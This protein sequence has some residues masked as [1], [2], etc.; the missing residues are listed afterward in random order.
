MYEG[1]RINR[2]YLTSEMILGPSHHFESSLS[3]SAFLGRSFDQS[4]G[5]NFILTAVK[6]CVRQVR[7]DCD[8]VE[9]ESDAMRNATISILWW[10]L[11]SSVD[12]MKANLKIVEQCGAFVIAVHRI[13]SKVSLFS[14]DAAAAAAAANVI[15]PEEPHI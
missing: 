3:I 11:G 10:T 6:K 13:G 1:S 14:Y 5:M 15:I 7:G 12:T 2:L 9:R 4:T 8:T